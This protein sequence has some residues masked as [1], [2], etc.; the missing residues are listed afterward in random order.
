[1]THRERIIASLNH[2]QPDRTC[3]D[4]SGHRSSSMS[5]IAY[6]KLREHLGLPKRDIRVFDVIQQLAVIDKDVLDLFDVDTVQLGAGF[7]LDD[8]MWKDWTLT[9][10][11]PAKIP[12]WVNPIRRDGAWLLESS[13]GTVIARM[14]DGALYFEQC[15]WP[16]LECDHPSKVQ[17]AMDDECPWTSVAVPPGPVSREELIKGAKALRASTDRA[18]IGAVGGKLFE[19][20]QALYGPEEFLAMLAGEP[21]RA[22]RF[23]DTVTEIHLSRI[24]NF[25]DAVGEYIDIVSFADDLGMQ[26]GPQIS[27]SMYREFFKPRH[28]AMY[29]G[30]KEMAD[31]KVL[32]HSCGSIRAFLPDLIQAGVDAVNPVQ[33]SCAGMDAADLKKDFGKDITF[34]G[35]GC[36]TGRILHQSTPKEVA[37]HVRKQVEILSPGGGFVF[38][39][40]HNILSNVPPENIVA[41]FEAVRR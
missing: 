40:V 32:L 3:I 18:I 4:L 29:K 9:D 10:G 36:D 31:V 16:L 14:P 1:M 39:Q 35:G 27:P 12:V 24:R 25:M 22:H 6:R 23:L 20:G 19:L 37:E 13:K 15:Y 26:S 38:Q 33:I 30:V 5:A 41:M 7:A 8:A 34:W 28:E 11:T 17:A 2:K 21:E